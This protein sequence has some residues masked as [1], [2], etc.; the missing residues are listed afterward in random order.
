MK[1]SIRESKQY[2]AQGSKVISEYEKRIGEH[3]IYIYLLAALL[4]FPTKTG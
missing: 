2:S 3:V 1:G 4:F